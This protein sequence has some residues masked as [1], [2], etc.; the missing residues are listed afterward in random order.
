MYSKTDNSHQS[1][2]LKNYKKLMVVTHFLLASDL[3]DQYV[4]FLKDLLN[5]NDPEWADFT[6]EILEDI[7]LYEITDEDIK[8]ALKVPCIC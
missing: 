3:E 1:G 4:D 7:Q 8:N 6:E 5:E 2:G